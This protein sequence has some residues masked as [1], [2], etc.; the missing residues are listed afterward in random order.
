M[1]K[2]WWSAVVV[3]AIVGGACG[4]AWTLNTEW[5]PLPWRFAAMGLVVVLTMVV[6]SAA[7]IASGYPTG[8]DDLPP[9]LHRWR[10]NPLMYA[11]AACVIGLAVVGTPILWDAALWLWHLITGHG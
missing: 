7:W 11:L 4:C 6:I 2:P 9:W 5:G 1:R 10:S 3:A 8:L